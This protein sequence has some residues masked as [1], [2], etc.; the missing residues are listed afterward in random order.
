MVRDFP[1]LLPD[2]FQ[3]QKMEKKM[4]DLKATTKKEKK[5]DVIILDEG[6]N[7]NNIIDPRYLLCC[8]LMI[9]PY[10]I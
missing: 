1:F 4:S 2:F 7:I 10:K 3:Y 9:F 5:E 8:L 6:I